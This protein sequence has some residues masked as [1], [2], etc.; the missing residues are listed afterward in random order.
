M[1]SVNEKMNGDYKADGIEHVSEDEGESV[2]CVD[3]EHDWK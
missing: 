2:V 1:Q 3:V